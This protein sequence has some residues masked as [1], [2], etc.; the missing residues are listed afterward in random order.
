MQGEHPLSWAS[1]SMRGGKSFGLLEFFA[2]FHSALGRPDPFP[3]ALRIGFPFADFI[4]ESLEPQL[5][6]QNPIRKLGRRIRKP[7][8]DLP[9]PFIVRSMEEGSNANGEPEDHRGGQNGQ[10]EGFRRHEG[11]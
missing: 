5:Q 8:G 2:L 7:L 9:G 1:F 6:L 4:D 11:N 10:E 3:D